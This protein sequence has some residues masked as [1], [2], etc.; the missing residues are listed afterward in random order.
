VRGASDAARGAA[1]AIHRRGQDCREGTGFIVQRN[2]LVADTPHCSIS[3]AAMPAPPIVLGRQIGVP[4][5]TDAT[6]SVK[7]HGA[8]Q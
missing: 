6:Y 8:L 3:F 7:V 1:P 4:A 2:I 5:P